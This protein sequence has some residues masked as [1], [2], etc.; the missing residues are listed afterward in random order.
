M[1][2][3]ISMHETVNADLNTCATRMVFQ[4][5][6]PIKVDFG[7]LDGHACSVSL[8]IRMSRA[9]TADRELGRLQGFDVLNDAAVQRREA[10]FQGASL[11]LR[12]P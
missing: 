3:W 12:F 7:Y 6:D 10:D 5:V 1:F 11:F 2:A 9:E 4:G 8:G